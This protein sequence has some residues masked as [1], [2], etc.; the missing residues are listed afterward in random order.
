M[1]VLTVDITAAAIERA[2]R[3]GAQNFIAKPFNETEVLLRAQNLLENRFMYTT[4]RS[5][6]VLARE[7]RRQCTCR[8]HPPADRW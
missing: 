1:L 8:A 6:I 7:G 4:R 2:L 3:D 5:S